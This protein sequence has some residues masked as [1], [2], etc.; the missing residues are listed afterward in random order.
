HEVCRMP[1]TVEANLLD[2]E[3]AIF[4]LQS[5]E[6]SHCSPCTVDLGLAMAVVDALYAAVAAVLLVWSKVEP[7]VGVPVD[8]TMPQQQRPH[9]DRLCGLARR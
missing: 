7:T 9:D 5:Y 6:L 8:V 1:R 3:A 4:D 2:A